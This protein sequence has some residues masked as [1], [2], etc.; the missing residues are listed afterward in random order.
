[1]IFLFPH[2]LQAFCLKFL[3]NFSHTLVIGLAITSAYLWL[4]INK[5][6]LPK[7]VSI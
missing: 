6:E 2:Q 5:F 3:V 1:L 4:Q 7:V